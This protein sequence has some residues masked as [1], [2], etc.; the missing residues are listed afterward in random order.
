MRPAFHP[1]LVNDPSGDPVLY[2]PFQHEG[3]ALLFDVGDLSPLA[4]REILKIEH[5]FVSHT[6]M[7]HF[8]GFDRLLRNLVGRRKTV[9]LY[10]PEGFLDCLGAKLA[11]Y[12]WNLVQEY[13]PLVFV[14]YELRGSEVR[15]RRYSSRQ[16]F[17]PTGESARPV[18]SGIL[19]D[20]GRFLVS[21]VA[22][23]HG[24]PC[25][26]FRLQERFHVSILADRV[27]EMGLAVGPWLND[28]KQA[29]YE[30]RDPAAVFPL[31]PSG[32]GKA[33]GALPLGDLA[34]RICRIT[35]GQRIV[36]VTD[37]APTDDNIQ[38]IESLAAGADRLFIEAAFLEA[39][40]DIAADKGHLTAALAGRIAG[41]AGV[42]KLDVFHH[43]PRYR[44]GASLLRA[45]AEEAFAATA[46]R[47]CERNE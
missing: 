1:R 27:R 20:R 18:Q 30:G 47:H 22:L 17:A 45:E 23:D 46:A 7:D 13:D 3:R 40:G 35:P 29:L 12:R 19:A 32:E 38:R 25:L 33:R 42:R 28:F 34:D 41:W 43:S 24:I 21:A 10:G 39:D 37:A 6:H 16:R 36:Y 9:F 8:F 26:G 15:N 2:V 11:G 31:P 44:D 4:P 5:V 14:A